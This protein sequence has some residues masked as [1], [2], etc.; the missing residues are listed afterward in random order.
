MNNT[1]T[2]VL[3]TNQTDVEIF[4]ED[5]PKGCIIDL[6]LTKVNKIY[7]KQT[8]PDIGKFFLIKKVM[9]GSLD[10]TEL[11]H[12]DDLCK[13]YNKNT[14]KLIGDFVPD[15]GNPDLVCITIGPDIYEKMVKY[16]RFIR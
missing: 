8:G 15:I 7:L 4:L 12:Y 10:I 14:N 1:L 13:V 3:D 16:A 9:L 11:M 6:D 2:L 5:Q